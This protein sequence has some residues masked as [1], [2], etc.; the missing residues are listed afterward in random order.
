[1]ERNP[2]EG[3]RQAAISLLR[4]RGIGTSDCQLVD[5]GLG[6]LELRSASG[7][8]RLAIVALTQDGRVADAW[9]TK[10]V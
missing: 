10:E 8:K 5:T 7:R 4:E 6:H 2:S 9:A 3:I 1:M